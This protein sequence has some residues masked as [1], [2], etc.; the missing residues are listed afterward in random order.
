MNHPVPYA[1]R[2]FALASIL[3]LISI[4]LLGASAQRA[5]AAGPALGY[6]SI[7]ALFS[8]KHPK[9]LQEFAKAVST[10]GSRKYQQYRSVQWIVNKY[11]AKKKTQKKAKRWLAARGIEAKPDATGQNLMATMT[12]EQA[13]SFVAGGASISS[14]VKDGE[15][16]VPNGLQG[17]VSGIDFLDPDTDKFRTAATVGDVIE[18]ETVPPGS[19]SPTI[20]S[21]RKRTGTPAGCAAGQAV[22]PNTGLAPFTPNQYLDAYGHST[23]HKQ[24]FKGQGMRMA[25]VEI[26]GFLRSDIEEFG[27]CFGVRVPPTQIVLA[28]IKKPLAPGGETTLDLEV[29]SAAAPQL[30]KIFVYQGQSSEVGLMDSMGS[31][32]GKKNSRPDAISMSI[33]GCEAFLTGQLGFR[34]GIDN[35][36]A[37]AAGAGIPFFISAGDVGAAGCPVGDNSTGLPFPAVQDPSSSKFA[38]AVGG[39][40]FSLNANNQITEEVVWNDGTE[41]GPNGGG[42]GVS[43]LSNRPWYQQTKQFNQY[44]PSRAV[45]DITGLADLYPGYSI[46]CTAP[47]PGGCGSSVQPNGGW[48]A[49]GGTSAATPLMAAGVTLLNQKRKKAGHRSL[50]FINPLIYKIGNSKAYGKAIRDVTVGN[51]DTGKAIPSSAGGNGQALGCCSAK[52]GYDTASGWGSLK[53]VGLGQV[54]AKYNPKR[55]GK[56]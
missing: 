13:E 33:G 51:N 48:S 20:G 43:I 54:A 55:S 24:G 29:I 25:V 35:I 53:L 23:L 18:A 11:G 44:G 26:D 21:A 56:K 1:S 3:L 49:V 32:L 16:Q 19:F 5:T 14:A 27:K 15:G 34:R 50:G 52:K 22:A 30:K 40:N 12:K 10:P 17:V 28:G 42:G 38:T 4:V 36:L 41:I 8:L 46:Y 39:S 47:G 31:A 6:N 45:P 9:G 37:V 7:N 2:R